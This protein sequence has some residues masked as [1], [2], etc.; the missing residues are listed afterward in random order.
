[1]P[2]RKP[3]TQP[4]HQYDPMHTALLDQIFRTTGSQKQTFPREFSVLAERIEDDFRASED[5]LEALGCASVTT[6]REQHARVLGNLH[7]AISALES[8]NAIPA[9]HALRDLGLWL[10][11]HLMLV[12]AELA[13][14]AECRLPLARCH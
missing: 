4:R 1:M 5:M 2:V 8:G 9:A 6:H 7:W 11:H 12:D 3:A 10:P 13:Q 14:A